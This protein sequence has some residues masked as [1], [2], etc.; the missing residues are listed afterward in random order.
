MLRSI[1]RP[2]KLFVGTRLRQARTERQLSQAHLA[3]L[4]GISPSYLNQ[5]ERDQRPLPRHMLTTLCEVLR[6]GTSYFDNSD[7]ARSVY[8]LREASADPALG[9]APL[10]LEEVT[11]AVR[12]APAVTER[13]LGLYRALLAAREAAA[14]G[15]TTPPILPQ[16]KAGTGFPYDE[17][18]DWV[19]AHRNHFATI[20]TAAELL[21]VRLALHRSDRLSGLAAYLGEK[22]G[23]EVEPSDELLR[24][25]LFWRLHRGRRR[26]L[27]ADGAS[28]ESRV[29][30]LAHVIGLLE[31]R[32]EIEK[33][34]RAASFS[35]EEVKSLAR[36]ALANYYAGALLMPYR[37]FLEVAREWRYDVERL[38]SR[39]GASFEQVCHRLSTMQRPG[40]P[41]LP[42]FFLKTDIAGN[43][44]KRSS[45]TR[46]QF[47][48][49]G[50]PCPLWNVYEA[51]AHP[52]QILVQI[53]RTPDE[54]TYLN[55]ARTVGRRGGRY[56]ARPRSVAIVLG[57][58][59][60]YARLTVYATG[61]DLTE[62]E[63]VPIGPGC[64]ACERTGCR[65]RAVPPLGRALDV[66]TVERGVVPYRIL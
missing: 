19:Q 17:V 41:G 39:F 56:L 27:L 25:G 59:I 10:G 61:L 33:L 23:L 48:R 28:E 37:A 49:F 12:Y 3:R 36:V 38:Q 8:D 63:S 13:F 31:Q 21:A 45:A 20:D 18:R 50:G 2:P 6:V 66:G 4:A 54:V 22:H 42:F 34:V 47:A 26:L 7:E 64:R 16:V 62:P 46:F 40:L 9:L 55:I 29:F 43:V 35:S 15:P 57:C 14:T 30:W 24:V 52:G 51:F 11:A 58:E 1:Q 5:I 44:L 53:A 65:H 32:R 60:E